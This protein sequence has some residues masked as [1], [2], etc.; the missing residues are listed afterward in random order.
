MLLIR[1]SS[2]ELVTPDGAYKLRTHDR[3]AECDELGCCI[4]NPS[5]NM[6]NRVNWL[7][8]W[9]EDNPSRG[10]ERIDPIYHIGHP[11]LD[12]QAWA[13]RHGYPDPG[14]GHGCAI[15][16]G[17]NICDPRAWA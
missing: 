1:N 7:Y 11:D 13:L 15:H 6:Q 14:L 10:M 17:Y 16:N 3:N 9:R 5:D 8:N 2:G 4:H 12:S